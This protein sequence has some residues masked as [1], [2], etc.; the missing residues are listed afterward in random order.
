M[1]ANIILILVQFLVYQYLKTMLDSSLLSVVLGSCLIYLICVC[2]RIVV[3]SKYCVVYFFVLC[4]LSCHFP[5]IVH[6]RLPL[7][8]SL[9][10][11]KLE[12]TVMSTCN[13]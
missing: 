6:F 9:T 2:L 13:H 10:F 4:T 8:Y 5:W 7:R 12:F 3:S 1:Q 11:I